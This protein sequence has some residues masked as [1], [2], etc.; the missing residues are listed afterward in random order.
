M[1]S[2]A[3]APGIDVPMEGNVFQTFL[4]PWL[5]YTTTGK[6]LD[7]AAYHDRARWGQLNRTW[8]TSGRPYRELDQIEG[9]PNPI[10]HRWLEHPSYDAYWQSMIPYGDEFARIR[11]PVLTTT[12]YYDGAQLGA[13]TTSPSTTH[14]LQAPSTIC[15]SVHMITLRRSVGRSAAWATR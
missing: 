1:P 13:S 11:I 15:S 12:G 3:V 14:A 7:D 5:F 8:Y 9:T 10:F 2:V 6:A 4:Y